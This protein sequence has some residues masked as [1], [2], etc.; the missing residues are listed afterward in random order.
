VV[1]CCD[2]E[3]LPMVGADLLRS[4]ETQKAQLGFWR[5]PVW[6][7]SSS[8]GTVPYRPIFGGQFGG[9]VRL[10]MRK[11]M[12]AMVWSARKGTISDRCNIPGCGPR[13]IKGATWPGYGFDEYFLLAAFYPRAARKG[14]L[15]FV[16]AQ[17]SSQLLLLDIEYVTWANSTSEVIYFGTPKCCTDP[18]SPRFAPKMESG[19]SADSTPFE[20][21]MRLE[22]FD[23]LEVENLT[24]RHP[25]PRFAAR[26]RTTSND[27]N[28]SVWSWFN[29]AS[30]E[31]R[32][33]H[34]LAYRTECSPRWLWS[35]LNLACLDQSGRVIPGSNR[36]LSL[37]TQYG[38]WGAEDPRF[39]VW[40]DRLLLTYN[41]GSRMGLA[42]IG[43]DGSVLWSR[44][45]RNASFSLDAAKLGG[46]RE[47]NWGLFGVGEEL[48]VSYW[49]SPHVVYQCD[50][51]KMRLGERWESPW[52]APTG[53]G[54]IHGGSAPVAH[55]GWMWRV[56]HSRFPTPFADHVV[57]RYRLWLLAFE[58]KP[59]FRVRWF[60]K[61]P[62]VVGR[63]DGARH[64]EQVPSHVVFC[65]S[66]ERREKG[67]R[68]YFGENDRWIRSGVIPDSLIEKRLEKVATV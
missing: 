40:Q 24:K 50:E 68:I 32:G 41:D 8:E 15:S 29:P 66:L 19:A 17:A 36:L 5:V 52:S 7:D 16:P 22:E 65:G 4:E 49:V 13:P 61:E 25:I 35:R 18:A 54:E 39:T 47:K 67:W 1:T 28:S 57:D 31:W 48:F 11:L 10:P 63:P 53:F 55:D 34:W 30:V 59:P 60:C 56:V 64:P 62:L 20:G 14:V 37:A 21:L 43:E 44:V 2:I 12:M 6:G 27:V 42:E 26:L 51:K 45:F 58:P 38:V 23:R 33:R 9:G 3:R 46:R